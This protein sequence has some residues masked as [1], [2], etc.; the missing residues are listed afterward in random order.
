[1]LLNWK[2]RAGRTII[3]GTTYGRANERVNNQARGT[4]AKR[5]GTR[6]QYLVGTLLHDWGWDPRPEIP[7]EGFDF[8]VEV[9]PTDGA[10]ARRFLVQVKGSDDMIVRQDGTWHVPVTQRRWDEYQ[11]HR[12]PVFIIGVDHET[13][14]FRWCDVKDGS[15]VVPPRLGFKR[16]QPTARKKPKLNVRLFPHKTLSRS[17]DAAFLSAIDRA[18]KTKDDMFHPP[19]V[20]TRV[21]A[22]R[23][24]EKDPRFQVT[25]NVVDGVESHI[26]Q[27]RGEPVPLSVAIRL[28]SK[29]DSHA[30]RNMYRF[31][32]PATVKASAIE[33]K[34]SRLFED[35]PTRGDL[36]VGGPSEKVRFAIGHLKKGTKTI[37]WD[38]EEDGQFFRGVDGGEWHH[39]CSD[40]PL[41]LRLRFE[42]VGS[43]SLTFG[44]EQSRWLGKD[45]SQLPYLQ[46]MRRFFDGVLDGGSI[47]LGRRHLGE[48]SVLAQVA[49]DDP[50]EKHQRMFIQA[51]SA[52]LRAVSAIAKVCAWARRPVAWAD[53]MGLDQ[54][55]LAL[56]MRAARLIDGEMLDEGVNHVRFAY[57][58]GIKDPNVLSKSPV[59]L[60]TP[61][62][63][64]IGKATEIAIPVLVTMYDYRV[65]FGGSSANEV[66]IKRVRKSS[67]TVRFDKAPDEEPS[68]EMFASSHGA[69]GGNREA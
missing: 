43:A 29:D 35:L 42:R 46:P 50:A 57:P 8:N 12:L 2:V 52:W 20:A 60:R 39:D 69:P 31:G 24:E 62:K 7:D 30:F 66:L 21:R 3:R 37:E 64:T 55:E 28:A 10:P 38:L 63:V 4:K 23:L 48:V 68:I 45:L 56:W 26:I 17:L 11:R 15:I 36:S 5:Q 58:E 65:T 54:S 32:T 47:V 61:Y 25:V 53:G 49:L 27:P 41:N 22:N 59:V 40:L 16:R 18:W 33:F 34:G 9:P 14:T 19:V 51:T 44:L 1:M 6:A 67:A 13:D